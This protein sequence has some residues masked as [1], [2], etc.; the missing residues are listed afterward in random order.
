MSPTPSFRAGLRRRG[1]WLGV[2]GLV[3]LAAASC[4]SR[5]PYSAMLSASRHV[6]GTTTKTVALPASGVGA[7]T[8]STG[9]SSIS[10]T[11]TTVKGATGQGS[12]LSAPGAGKSQAAGSTGGNASTPVSGS[13]SLSTVYVGNV[14]TY[15]GPAGQVLGDIPVG[16]QIWADYA[17]AHGGVNGHPVKVLVSDD[18]SSPSAHQAD[19]AAML[20]QN[21]V[22]AFVGNSDAVAGAGSESYIDSVKTPVIGGDTAGQYYNTDPYY[23]PQATSGNAESESFMFGAASET[24][25]RKLGILTSSDTALGAQQLAEDKSYAPQAGFNVVYSGQASITTPDFT[26][27]CL[28][29]NQAGVQVFAV[30]LDDNSIGRLA[31]NCAQ[32]NFHPVFVLGGPQDQTSQATN[33]NMQGTVSAGNTFP[34]FLNN[35]PAAQ[36]FQTAVA[37]YAPGVVPSGGMMLGWISG[38]LFGAAA[39]HLPTNPTSQDVLN[40]LWAIKNDTLG[41]LTYPLTFNSGQATPTPPCWFNMTIT[42]NAWAS[43]DAGAL[44]CH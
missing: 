23:F 35:T 4:G 26:A 38:L 17:N 27:Q 5:Q 29:A 19:L 30:A 18:Q 14:G 39:V 12:G 36:T 21:H 43:P 6:I 34:W 16:V 9:T 10:S 7:S 15:S 3:S 44:H 11:T 37:K 2:A 22:I 8:S 42:N 28:S 13:A 25:L 33:P 24:S 20:Q 32:Q 31:S 1:T 40:G 41:G